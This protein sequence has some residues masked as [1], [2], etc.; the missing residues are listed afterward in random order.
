MVLIEAP[1]DFRQGH[2]S[3]A[4]RQ[5]HDY[6][7]RQHDIRQIT[8][9][10]QARWRCL[11]VCCDPMQDRCKGALRILLWSSNHFDT[12]VSVDLNLVMV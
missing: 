7:S 3:V 1:A 12:S 6:A 10:C 2:V 11:E 9:T 4:S 8:F 5:K